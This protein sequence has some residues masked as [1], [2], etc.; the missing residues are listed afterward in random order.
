MIVLNYALIESFCALAKNLNFTKAAAEIFITQPSLSRNIVLLENELGFQLFHRSK[1]SVSLTELGERFLPY[2]L[3]I[4]EANEKAVAF[5]NAIAKNAKSTVVRELR[6][7]IATMLFTDLIPALISYMASEMPE[8]HFSL[9]DGTQSDMLQ[10]LQDGEQD[11]IFTEG[12]AL[13]GQSGLEV[14]HVKRSDMKLVVPVGHAATVKRGPIPLSVLP[15]YGIPLLTIDKTV[16]SKFQEL[17]PTVEI[18]QYHSAAR[19]LSMVAAGFGFCICHEGMKSFSPNSVV[20][21]DL[22]K[23][24]FYMDAAIAWRKSAATASWYVKFFGKLRDFLEQY[25]EST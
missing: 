11:I 5:S 24:P 23:N 14:I 19:A 13:S 20:F 9:A 8:I 10:Q 18:R 22:D 12:Q 1:H 6:V 3:H 25:T 17:L 16:H 4:K 15:G 2:A 21:L 7:G